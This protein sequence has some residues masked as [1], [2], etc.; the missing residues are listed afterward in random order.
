[1][2]LKLYMV[3][4]YIILFT[5]IYYTGLTNVQFDVVCVYVCFIRV[6]Q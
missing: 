6:Q 3:H 1:M 5:Y 4:F 2:S